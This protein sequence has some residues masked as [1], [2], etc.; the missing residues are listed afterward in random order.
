MNNNP[1]L[2]KNEGKRLALRLP[3]LACFALFAAWQTGVVFYSGTSF[4]I[5]GNTPL[6]ETLEVAYT[7]RAGF[8]LNNPV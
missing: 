5:D 7:G 1:L 8:P 4:T 6:P 2:A 3:L